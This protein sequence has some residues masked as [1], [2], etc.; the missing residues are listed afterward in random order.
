[1]TTLRVFFALQPEAAQ[2][3][4]LVVDVAP[5]V[6]EL[7]GRAVVASNL[8]ATLCFVGAI[9]EERLPALREAAARVRSGPVELEFD[10]LEFWREPEVVVAVAPASDAARD[11]SSQLFDV[12]I[13]AA[14]E[15]DRKPFRPH[16]TLAR[17]VR[18]RLA[19]NFPWPRALEKRWR[20]RCDRFVLMESR[21]DE[22]GSIYSV[23]ESWPLDE[24]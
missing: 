9:E 13:A 3:A 1:M 2:R 15:P 12:T 5:L 21:R 14:F 10:A 7:G 6:A 17:K 19:E 24:K 22:S 23:V 11:L 4:G 20:V 18:A 16:L 8:H